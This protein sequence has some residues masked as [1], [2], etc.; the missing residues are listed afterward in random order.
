MCK[1]QLPI[2]DAFGIVRQRSIESNAEKVERDP[3]K[4]KIQIATI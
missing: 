3:T 2:D 4:A 1:L